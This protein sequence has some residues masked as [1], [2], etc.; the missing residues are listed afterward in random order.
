M[1]EEQ[2][3]MTRKPVTDDQSD[4]FEATDTPDI[5]SVT[6]ETE[7][8]EEAGPLHQLRPPVEDFVGREDAIERLVE[9]LS[10]A[11]E[12]ESGATAIIRGVGGV[13]KTE[14]AYVVAQR[15]SDQFPD[16]RF[17]LELHGSGNE[18]LLPERALQQ[19]I[20]AFEPQ[21][22][23][24][25]NLDR[26]QRR[27]RAALQGR[28]VLILAD[29]ASDAAQ[30][31]HLLPPA[32]CALL[33]T[34]RE[35]FS[36]PGA[37][38]EDL[39]RMSPDE[40]TRLL[41]MLSPR[42]EAAAPRLAEAGGW[43]PLTLRVSAGILAGPEAG[44]TGETGEPGE[45]EMGDIEAYVREVEARRQELAAQ[46]E[47]RTLPLPHDP[48]VEAVLG[49]SYDHL[50]PIEQAAL[51]QLSI[52]PSGF[53]LEGLNAVVNLRSIKLP[54]A[55]ARKEPSPGVGKEKGK[56]EEASRPP[57]SRGRAAP[58]SVEQVVER[59]H[60]CH[61]LTYDEVFHRYQVHEL[62]RAF[63]AAQVGE[64]DDSHAQ[65]HAKHYAEVAAEV[66]QLYQMGDEYLFEGLRTFDRERVHIDA[67]W[68]WARNHQD[69]ELILKYA[70]VLSFTGVLRYHLQDEYLPRAE[71]A[72][73][74]ARKLRRRDN[75]SHIL[76][77]LGYAWNILGEAR[78]AVDFFVQ[79]LRVLR[80]SGN[81]KR[82]QKKEGAIISNL[83][84]AYLR[85]GEP[86]KSIEQSRLRL[87]IAIAA[88]DWRGEGIALNNL[89]LA[90][91]DL[92]RVKQALDYYQKSLDL[93]RK[94][95][96][97]N[98]EGTDLGNMGRA[99]VI[100]GE[101][102]KAIELCEQA[103]TIK[104]ELGNSRDEGYALSF[105]GASCAAAGD[106]QRALEHQQQALDIAQEVEDRW[107][108]AAVLNDLGETFLLRQNG[109]NQQNGDNLD[110]AIELF[111]RALTIAQDIGDRRGTALSGWNLARA[112]DR[113]GGEDDQDG[114]R[115]IAL[116][117]PR[118][119][120]EEDIG[121]PDAQAHAEEVA[122]VRE[123]LGGESAETEPGGGVEE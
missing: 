17:L 120:Y 20:H 15:L 73:A 106:I 23:L 45:T 74:V 103:L 65:R 115:L 6:E 57:K 116:M 29:D 102:N 11:E 51:R 59:L 40:A 46:A 42:L 27:Y 3:Q 35:P 88:N 41:A 68:A 92:G 104:W 111:E 71:E 13:G 100:L 9:A 90:Y 110:A 96:E 82:K 87:E 121:H 75:E 33:V 8:T 53:D 62:V 37:F 113:R 67:G 89:G 107:L 91:T 108:E 86:K 44:E 14:L 25:S 31:E 36:L 66:E 64:G 55:P 99:Y 94:Y 79:A 18:A 105:L 69:D 95:G 47:H 2:D 119:D 84:H 77:D 93:S 38:L 85:L 60:R 122:Q 78:R 118:V 48:E 7:E 52:F 22:Q 97:R 39:E 112:L 56:G 83:S 1:N 70:N 123:R 21:A 98:G 63:A 49:V 61:L 5:T 30:V 72:L 19:L 58:P 50:T 16:D 10:S 114:H 81:L 43:L 12:G 28:R 76:N 32:G 80:T 101:P 117:Q 54:P 24:S 109:Q 34:T 4:P 26:L